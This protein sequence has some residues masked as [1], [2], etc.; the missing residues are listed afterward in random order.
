MTERFHD[1]FERSAIRLREKIALTVDGY[2]A[3][4]GELLDH[5]SSIVETLRDLGIPAGARV[6]IYSEMSVHAVA[7]AL[8]IL[9][10]GCILA[11]IRHTIPTAELEQQLSDC[12]ASALIASRSTIPRI[13]LHHRAVCAGSGLSEHIACYAIRGAPATTDLETRHAATTHWI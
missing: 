1:Y 2:S 5:M 8:G 13:T 12:G 4:Y 11:C 10:A 6:A 3:T 9:K 7:A